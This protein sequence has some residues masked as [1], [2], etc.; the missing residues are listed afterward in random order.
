[1]IILVSGL[2]FALGVLALGA[3]PAV[4]ASSVPSATFTSTRLTLP[5]S[6]I[7]GFPAIAVRG[8]RVVAS[9]AGPVLWGSGDGGRS[10]TAPQ[11]PNVARCAGLPLGLDDVPFAADGAM[12]A[13]QTCLG[14]GGGVLIWRSSDAGRSWAPPAGGRLQ[15]VAAG[16]EVAMLT[17]DPVDPRVLYVVGEALDLTTL[18]VWR[19]TDAGRSFAL[20]GV[21]NV[22]RTPEALADDGPGGPTRLLID[23][24]DRRRL[25]VLWWSIAKRQLAHAHAKPAALASRDAVP[26]ARARIAAPL[27]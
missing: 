26:R 22:P 7:A 9:T 25:Y 19:S 17:A 27:T 18:V 10:F 4:G 8:E 3:R 15:L 6:E 2:M 11:T 13:V 23:P 5:A 24:T 21:I 20:H 12:F 1:M 14:L 16:M